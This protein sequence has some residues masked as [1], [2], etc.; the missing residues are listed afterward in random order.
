MVL[1]RKGPTPAGG[2][3]SEAYLTDAA[4]LP[5]D[6]PGAAAAV[7]IVE[8]DAGGEEIA[9]TY[10]R[11]D[12]TPVGIDS[13]LEDDD[14]DSFQGAAWDLYV[15]RGGEL[16][17]VETLDDLRALLDADALGPAFRTTVAGMLTLPVWVNAP[18]AL[19]AEV[20]EWLE[21]TRPATSPGPPAG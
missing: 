14:L 16:K 12:I 2:V 21:Q 19:R 10:G 15:T 1:T 9:R 18:E 17:P 6:D 11:T 4:G 3:R 13:G 5:T 20:N 8:Y 7:E